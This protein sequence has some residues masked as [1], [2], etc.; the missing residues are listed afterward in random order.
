VEVE[1]NTLTGRVKVVDQFHAAAAG[2]VVNPMGYAGQIEGGSSMAIGF[3]LMED[4]VMQEGQYV[5]GN[6][7]AYLIPTAADMPR[8]FT[9]EA[10]ETLPEGDPYGPRGIGEVGTVA[11]APAITAAIHRAAGE[12][13]ER[14]PVQPERLIRPFLVDKGRDVL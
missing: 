10:I 7:D 14:L 11:L 1:V 3:T 6:L 9:L 13:I 12:W 5:T 4:A 8:G 2:P